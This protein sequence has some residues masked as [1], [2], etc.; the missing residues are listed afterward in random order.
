MS[1]AVGDTA[2][3][4]KVSNITNKNRKSLGMFQ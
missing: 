4:C 2:L 3:E 1:N